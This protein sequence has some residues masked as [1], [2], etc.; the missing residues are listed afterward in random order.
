MASYE[1]SQ[2]RHEL[3]SKIVLRS[4]SF[5]LGLFLI[6][7]GQKFLWDIDEWTESPVYED[8]LDQSKTDSV[9]S[10]LGI[11]ETRSYSMEEKKEQVNQTL[12]V[13][14]QNYLSEKESFDNWIKT[15]QTLG[16]PQQDTEVI[17]RARKLDDL[18]AV[19]EAWRAE[20][21]L[22]E[23]SLKVHEKD[24]TFLY[25]RETILENHA[26]DRYDEAMK[27]YDL[28]VFLYRMIF[29]LPVLLIGIFL[30]IKFRKHRLSSLIWGYSIFSL[31]IFFVGLVPYLPSYGGYIRYG[32]GIILTVLAAI[33]VIKQLEKY[34][35]RRKQELQ[36]SSEQRA[37]KIGYDIAI[38]AFNAH[39]CPSCGRDF[40]SGTGTLPAQVMATNNPRFCL[41]CGLKLFES[42]GDCGNRNFV[43]FLHCS[44][45]G[46]GLQKGA[47][48]ET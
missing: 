34:A 43:H 14:R 32:V 22:V 7:L 8:F 31:Y 13:A 38:K 21:M 17:S 25:Q 20:L 18:R 45:C 4:I 33:Y 40:L 48:G 46:T 27:S 29:A 24:H 47:A 19:E 36:K 2:K 10:A 16:S 37:S 3:V 1:G 26:R 44:N 28:K 12:D 23:D 41:H 5:I 11:L 9:R 42:C 35:E 39:T 6:L 15:R 30:F